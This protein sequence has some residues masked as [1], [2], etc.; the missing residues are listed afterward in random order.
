M[1][2]VVI[3]KF[4]LRPEVRD[5]PAPSALCDESHGNA[6]PERLQQLEAEYEKAR[7]A[8]VIAAWSAG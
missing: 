1:R 8:S 5:L 2:A 7:L 3:E 4:G 6:A